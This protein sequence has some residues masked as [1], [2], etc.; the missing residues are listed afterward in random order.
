MFQWQKPHVS[1]RSRR[2]GPPAPAWFVVLV[3]APSIIPGVLRE[4]K[5][6][7][8]SLEPPP[9]M[10]TSEVAEQN[11]TLSPKSPKA[12]QLEA[13][14]TP[15]TWPTIDEL[16]QYEE[17]SLSSYSFAPDAHETISAETLAVGIMMD[18]PLTW[19]R[20]RPVPGDEDLTRLVS[21]VPEPKTWALMIV[22][23]FGVGATLR[24]KHRACSQGLSPTPAVNVNR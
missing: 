16:D 22:A 2:I 18:P 19:V 9:A 10:S 8:K 13:E 6:R 15:S 11:I 3:I 21:A 17:L 23:F 14:S 20:G 7:T 24:R 1:K 12:E 4:G 5:L